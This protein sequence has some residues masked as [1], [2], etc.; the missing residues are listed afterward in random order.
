MDGNL[1]TTKTITKYT[2]SLP[3]TGS[4]DVIYFTNISGSKLLYYYNGSE[5]VQHSPITDF[6]RDYY[7]SYNDINLSIYSGSIKNIVV[8]EDE[9]KEN[10][11]TQYVYNGSNIDT[12]IGDYD[13]N[14]IQSRL[15][16]LEYIPV[17]IISFNN[18]LNIVEKGSTIN[19]IPFSWNLN[20]N[21]NSISINNGIGNIS[22][23][24]RTYTASVNINTNTTYTLTVNDGTAYSGS[25]DTASTSV[26]FQDKMYIGI[27]SNQALN[28]SQIISLSGSFATSRSKAF[29]IN[30]NGQYIHICYP[31][32]FGD[33]TFNVNG[34]L[35]NAF[36]KNLISFTNSQG[37]ISNYYDYRSNTI[38][39]GS[40]IQITVS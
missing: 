14:L 22:S 38:Q 37:Y 3:L 12:Q 9:T 24:L 1:T 20:K 27:N 28:S 32:S 16:A 18:S 17:D 6:Q 40:S 39:N 34:L 21:V 33:A 13:I 31:A 7:A 19:S 5:Y 10:N 15:N 2:S 4:V 8:I 23:S 25:I 29:T 11:L 35:S 30:G 26:L 36:T